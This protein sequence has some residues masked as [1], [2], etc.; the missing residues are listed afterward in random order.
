MWPWEEN[1]WLTWSLSMVIDLN[2]YSTPLPSSKMCL[3]QT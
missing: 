1:N 3:G 2:M